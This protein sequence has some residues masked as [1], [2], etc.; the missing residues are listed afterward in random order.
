MSQGEVLVL[1]HEDDQEAVQKPRLVAAGAD[2][3]KVYYVH[4][5]VQNLAEDTADDAERLQLEYDI[6]LIKEALQQKAKIKLLIFDPLPEFIAGDHNSSKEVRDA[7]QPLNKLA[8]EFNIAVI[9]ICHQNKKQGLC[10]ETIAG[11]GGFSQVARRS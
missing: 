8:Q 1:G 11:S 7:L 5:K 10:R 4:G 6:K 9:A 3:D 2:C